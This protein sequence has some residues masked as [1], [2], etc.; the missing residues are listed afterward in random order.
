MKFDDLDRQMRRFEL[1]FDRYLPEDQFIIARL[2]GRSFTRLTKV[3]LNFERPFDQ[4]FHDAMIHTCRHLMD[5]GFQAALCY[6]Q[7][8]EISLLLDKKDQIFQRKERKFLSLIAGEASGAFSLAMGHVACFD[9]RLCPL[10]KAQDVIGYFRWRTEDARRNALS[11]YCYWTLRGEGVLP[12]DADRQ[13]AGLSTAEKRLLL[14][15]RGIDFE[16][17][18][19]WKRCGVFLRWENL[20]H[21][22][23]NPITGEDV[24]TLRR[25]I[26]Q[27]PPLQ[28]SGDIV[29]L[30]STAVA[31][32]EG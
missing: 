16:A 12:A 29:T 19:G 30:V 8:D 28:E 5:T 20:P 13:L 27:L 24:I 21:A 14:R 7:S 10:P 4:R 11:A 18:D 1:S 15:E 9:C 31:Q 2:D 23:Q 25:R 6:T 3:K 26:T 22:G 32:M 17:Q